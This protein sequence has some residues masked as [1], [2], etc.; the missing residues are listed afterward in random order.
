MRGLLDAK[1]LVGSYP[2]GIRDAGHQQSKGEVVPAVD[3]QFLDVPFADRVG[4][5]ASL[6]FN[7]RR[8]RRHFDN[9]RARRDF[10]VKIQ[11]DSLSHG[12]NHILNLFDL[13]TGRMDGHRVCCRRESGQ[14]I[15]SVPVGLSR[16][17]DSL[18]GFLGSDCGLWHERPSRVGYC[19]PDVAGRAHTLPARRRADRKETQR[20]H[21]DICQ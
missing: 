10:Q 15:F 17:P 21:Q 19:T 2:S 8:F 11:N 4:L 14:L 12:H 20:R 1:I 5:V 18:I 13:E 16:A 6:C 7:D 3:G 9:L